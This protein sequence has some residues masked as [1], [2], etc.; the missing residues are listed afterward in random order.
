MITKNNRINLLCYR[1]NTKN[2]SKIF[3]NN[4]TVFIVIIFRMKMNKI[5]NKLRKIKN[6]Q[7]VI[8][9]NDKRI[10]F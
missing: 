4:S 10:L 6:M 7:T 5:V 1:K 9:F 2:K 3:N 8:V